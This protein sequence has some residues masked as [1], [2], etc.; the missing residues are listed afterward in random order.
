MKNLSPLLFYGFEGQITIHSQNN[1]L[2]QT[3]DDTG[4]RYEYI[5]R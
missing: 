2:R 3:L 1:S 4:L 5:I